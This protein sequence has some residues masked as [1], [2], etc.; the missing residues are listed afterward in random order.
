MMK[1]YKWKKA[2]IQQLE[3]KEIN[4]LEDKNKDY[5]LQGKIYKIK[6]FIK[7]FRNNSFG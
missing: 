3:N 5:Q 2:I 7:R 4:Y 1:Y 6:M